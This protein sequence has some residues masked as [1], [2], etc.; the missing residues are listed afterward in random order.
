MKCE[1]MYLLFCTFLYANLIKSSCTR[2]VYP[3]IICTAYL[4]K[5]VG[6]YKSKLTLGKRQAKTSQKSTGPPQ[7]FKRASLHSGIDSTHLHTIYFG[8]MNGHSSKIYCVCWCFNDRVVEW[9][10]CSKHHHVYQDINAL[11]Q[12]KGDWSEEQM[13]CS[14]PSFQDKSEQNNGSK[15]PTFNLTSVCISSRYFY[16]RFLTEPQTLMR[17]DIF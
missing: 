15:L 12:H 10:N 16:C 7:A 4:L 8:R 1:K 2:L 13:I 9:S 6:K 5:V 11:S 3:S 17:T 14:K